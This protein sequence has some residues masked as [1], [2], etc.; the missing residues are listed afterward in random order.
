MTVSPRAQYLY[1]KSVVDIDQTAWCLRPQVLETAR[2]GGC[3]TG[4]ALDP[5][6]NASHGDV[7]QAEYYQQMLQDLRAAVD[8]ELSHHCTLL[9]AHE[10]NGDT[11]G[12]RRSQRIIR[13]KE[14]ELAA[15]DRLA[16]ALSSR[17]P[18]SQIRSRDQSSILVPG[19]L[20]MPSGCELTSETA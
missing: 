14:S 12:V 7:R 4:A 15:I 11:P 8:D 13:V 16:D 10:A 3:S 6:A 20:A 5:G 1:G 2:R 17:F 19:D 18:T 9:A